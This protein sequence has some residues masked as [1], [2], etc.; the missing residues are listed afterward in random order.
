M[1]QNELSIEIPNELAN[2]L[3]N[4]EITIETNVS[5]VPEYTKRAIKNYKNR[6]YKND[7]IYR[8]TCIALSRSYYQEKKEVCKMKRRYTYWQSKNQL[9][10]YEE[11]YPDDI[12]KLRDIGFLCGE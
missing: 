12:I 6:K 5:K 9:D 2:E 7:E 11:K 8:E 10:K 4:I 3:S 1:T